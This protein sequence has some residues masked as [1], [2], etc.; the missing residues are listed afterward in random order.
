MNKFL[1]NTKK[2][3]SK[4][5]GLGG[6]FLK[7]KEKDNPKVIP[8]A[9]QPEKTPTQPKEANEETQEE[10]EQ[11]QAGEIKVYAKKVDYEIINEE[12]SRIPCKTIAEAEILRGVIEIKLFLKDLMEQ[13]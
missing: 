6:R 8:P 12:G 10:Q 5:R 2:D 9:K 3:L 1:E 7:S 4:L 11:L 13:K